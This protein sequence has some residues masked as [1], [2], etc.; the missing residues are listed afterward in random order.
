MNL[1]AE[2]RWCLTGTPVQ[3]WLDDLFSLLQFL[4]FHPFQTLPN[5]RKYILEPLGRQD[6]KGLRNLQLTMEAI[7]LRK[8]RRQICNQ[9]R[10]EE[11]LYVNL[12]VDERQRYS[13][14]LE[15]ARYLARTTGRKRGKN[16]LQS[17]LALRQLCSH[18]YLRV[19]SSNLHFSSNNRY[20]MPLSGS[21]SVNCNNCD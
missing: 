8:G 4:R 12:N 20:G 13:S 17:I 6:K 21:P 2:R 16:I 1:K 11:I 19:P 5:A 14:I 18:G 9:H 15:E 10:N 3:N 7:S